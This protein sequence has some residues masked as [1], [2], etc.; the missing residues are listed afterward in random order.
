MENQVI[1]RVDPSGLRSIGESAAT[2][3]R[4][5][6]VP[7]CGPGCWFL[8]SSHKFS[9][10]L[11]YTVLEWEYPPPTDQDHIDLL[12]DPDKPYQLVVPGTGEQLKKLTLHPSFWSAVRLQGGGRLNERNEPGESHVPAGTVLRYHKGLQKDPTP[13]PLWT[14]AMDLDSLP[15]Y[16]SLKRGDRIC[17][18]EFTSLTPYHGNFSFVDSG[19]GGDYWLD[20]YVGEGEESKTRNKIFRT[21]TGV[22]RLTVLRRGKPGETC[23]CGLPQPY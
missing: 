20:I 16:G 3:D 22:S 8:V 9:S 21:G 6:E 12:P 10:S 17:I 14:V 23:P 5:F 15:L 19:N 1:N 7:E 18:P 11:Y 4:G 2:R 13:I